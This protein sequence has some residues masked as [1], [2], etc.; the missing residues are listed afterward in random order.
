MLD[1]DDELF[2]KFYG[3]NQSNLSESLGT[4]PHISGFVVHHQTAPP[5]TH[6]SSMYVTSAQHKCSWLK[7]IRLN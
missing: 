4:W 1:V 6:T 5:T 3:V 2:C 7:T